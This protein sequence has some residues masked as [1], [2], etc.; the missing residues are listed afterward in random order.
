M[1]REDNR[2]GY[3]EGHPWYYVRGG[4]VLTPRQICE[5]ARTSGYRGYMRHDIEKADAL[6]EPKRSAE[7]RAIREKVMIDLRRDLSGYRRVVFALHAL[8]RAYPEPWDKPSCD[9][10][11]TAVSLK[12]SH[13]FSDFAH[14]IW[15]DDLLMR[16]PDLFT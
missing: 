1:A 12:H 7:L 10:V 16:Q 14:L 15:L 11:H 8:R 3:S 9:D 6:A 4:K 2:T 5:D 13:L